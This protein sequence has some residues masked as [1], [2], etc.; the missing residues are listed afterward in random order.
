M[1]PAVPLVPGVE[2][3]AGVAEEAAG[4]GVG[5]WTTGANVVLILPLAYNEAKVMPAP[6]KGTRIK[7]AMAVTTPR[8][9]SRDFVGVVGN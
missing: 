4:V 1:V 3:V 9:E 7:N 6:S 2:L 5:I 8:A